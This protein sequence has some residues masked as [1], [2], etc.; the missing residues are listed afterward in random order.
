MTDMEPDAFRQYVANHVQSYL[1]TD[2]EEGAIFNGVPC[3]ILT[4]LGAKSGEIRFS[5]VIRVPIPASEDYVVV[6]SMG[7]APRHPAWYFNMTAQPGQVTLQ[8]RAVKRSYRARVAEGDEREQLWSLA[9][10]IYPKYDE[11]QE[12]TERVIPVLRLTPID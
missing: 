6:A 1:D 11:Y 8:D 5:P 2:G 9:V 12:R 4:T 7:G 3:V 10:S